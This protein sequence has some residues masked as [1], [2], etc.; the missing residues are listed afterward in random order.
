MNPGESSGPGGDR[1]REYALAGIAGGAGAGF[2]TAYLEAFFLLLTVG[3]FWV[4]LPFLIS[5]LA[6]YG[7][8]G[9]IGGLAC[10]LLLQPLLFRRHPLR[11]TRPWIF[12]FSLLSAAGLAAETLLY[13]LDIHTFRDFNGAWTA[14]AYLV[15]LAGFL[16]AGCAGML[17]ARI[18]RR[19]FQ[20]EGTPRMRNGG[21]ALFALLGLFLLARIL[22]AW[23]EE[24]GPGPA[25]AGGAAR[26][27]NVILLVVD[28]LRPDHLS[29]YGYPLPTSPAIDRLAREGTLF[30]RLLRDLD[31]EHPDPCLAFHRPLPVQPRLLFPVFIP[32]PGRPD[33]GAG[34]RRPGLPDRQFLRQ[35]PARAPMGFVAR[36]S[37]RVGRGQRA[38]GLADAPESVGSFAR[39]SLDEQEHPGGRREVGRTRRRAKPA[40]LSVHESHGCPS[41][42]SSAKTVQRRFLCARSRPIR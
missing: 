23:Q 13:L 25:P 7:A 32:G 40:F 18:G 20:G 27:A 30:P 4:D 33:P 22:L 12:F 1:F 26:P 39:G 11:R 31:L 14:T 8:A 24:S 37:D 38:Q 2:L 35:P 36:V 41:S 10:S 3:S 29:A 9:A 28:A 16:A 21:I 6:L 15:L 5:A 42:L 17:I 19:L 34:P